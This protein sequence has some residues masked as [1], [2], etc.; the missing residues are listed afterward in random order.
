MQLE[1]EMTNREQ[2]L[3]A[4]ISRMR[5]ENALL[6]DKVAK[7]ES[8][9][10]VRLPLISCLW[11]IHFVKGFNLFFFVSMI[12]MQLKIIEKKMKLGSLLKSCELLSR[13]SLKKL[14]KTL[15]LPTRG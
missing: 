13:N 6:Q 2:E 10:L 4:T 3:N 8:E 14:S 7:E 15:Q 9:K 1:T 11:F 5:Q 12:R